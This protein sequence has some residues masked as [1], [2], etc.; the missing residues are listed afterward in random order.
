MV[1]AETFNVTRSEAANL[2]GSRAFG[3]TTEGVFLALFICGLAWVPYWLGSNR[4]I[5]WGINAIVFPGL[6]ASYE[7]SLLLRGMHHPVPIRR[8]APS[9]VLFALAASWAVIQNVTWT[10]SGWQHPIWQLVSEALGQHVPGS[11]SIDRD[12]TAIALL[13][14]MTAASTFWLALQLS[15]D[16]ARAQLLIWAVV[17]ISALYAAVG[18]YALG[19]MPNGR[20]F[21]EFAL[22]KFVSSTFVSQNHYVTFA[23]MGFL[24]ATAA[25][26]R[27]YRQEFGRSGSLL[28][29]KVAAL[30]STTG[31][32]AAVPLAFASVILTALLLTGNR[33]GIISAALGLFVLGSL[34]MRRERSGWNEALLVVFAALLVGAA[35]ISLG[36]VFVGRVTTQ[37]LYDSGRLWVQGLTIKSIVSAPLLGF[38]YGTFAVAFPM[39][40]DDGMSILGFW[41]KAHN[42]Y[43]EIF[44]GLG[45]VFGGMLIASVALLVWDCLQGARTRKHGA[46][47]P[48]LAVS[49]SFL[50]GVHALVDF[51]LQIQAVTLTYMAVLGAGVAQASDPSPSS[52]RGVLSITP[53]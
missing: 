38:G 25:I 41:D 4:P 42:T 13:R 46:T 1:A 33:G 24:A 45:I 17:G 5:A 6:A 52:D 7:V 22:S 30:I 8:V 31:S 47:V 48:A 2:P 16:A 34:I 12:L 10:P 32:K 20:V 43:L 53:R 19:F 40:R 3:I 27:L 51:S 26:L 14:L 21:P 18:L 15:R 37:G 50:V 29:L 9:A 39:F 49:I 36:D 23:G 11:I 44:Q 28:R 35:F